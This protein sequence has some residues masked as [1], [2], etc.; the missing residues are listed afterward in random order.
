MSCQV[1]FAAKCVK[2]LRSKVCVLSKVFFD[3]KCASAFQ[4]GKFD[5]FLRLFEIRMKI[6]PEILSTL[7]F[8]Y[9][10]STLKVLTR[11]A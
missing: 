9:P 4:A 5:T 6:P 7:L 8:V 11:I 2:L 10:S 3:A 1:F